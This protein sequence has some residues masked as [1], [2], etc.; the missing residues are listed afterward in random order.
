MPLTGKHALIT[1][2][3]RGIG[4]GIALKLAEH[5]V[6]IAVHYYQNQDAATDTLAKVR[7]HG[8][9]G[10]IIQA[11]V[12]RPED[13]RR[14]FAEVQ[15]TFGSLDIFVSNARPDLPT[16]YQPPLDITLDQWRMAIDSQA[17]AFLLGAQEAN[18]LMANGG[19]LIAVTYSPSGRTG[20]WQPW[21]GM[22]AAKAALDALVRYFAVALGPRGIAVNGVS[23]GGVFGPPNMVEGSVLRI[24]PTEVQDAIG[25][26]HE[27]GW[28]PMR[29]LGTPEDIGNAVM[30]LCRDEASFI[31]GQII[32]VDGGASIMDSVF[33][34]NIQQG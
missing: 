11:D 34:L 13:I 31:T 3:S 25:A 32:H 10:V 26:W 7:E 12:S 17:Q 18:R 8:V 22:G 33:P 19:R 30:L 15:E 29:R 4:R 6:N 9:D 20:S 14:M 27:S 16:F 2:G 28:T 5:G 24:L 1:G 21:V 23:P